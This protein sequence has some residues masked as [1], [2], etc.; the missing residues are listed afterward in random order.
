MRN[1]C[2]LHEKR[3]WHLELP[4]ARGNGERLRAAVEHALAIQSLRDTQPAEVGGLRARA[5]QSDRTGR[6]DGCLWQRRDDREAG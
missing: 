3:G 6:T 1:Q 5:A 2:D 4:A